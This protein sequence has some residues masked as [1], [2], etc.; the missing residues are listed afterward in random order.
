M[1]LLL[2]YTKIAPEA[3]KALIGLNTYS[4]QSSISPNLR[5]LLEVIVSNINGCSYCIE[6]HKQQA[7]D[8]GETVE[9]LQ[10]LDQWQSSDL[11]TDKEKSAFDWAT[12]VTLLE[13]DKKRDEF[14][15]VLEK[16]YSEKEIVDLTFIILTMNAW[17]RIAISFRHEAEGK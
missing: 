16:H 10:A 15:S 11:F 13:S 1:T 4:E 17:N 3:I 8:L 7:F 12:N 14:F 5:R 9:R 6:T 2:D